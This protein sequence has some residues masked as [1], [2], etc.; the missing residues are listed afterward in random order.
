[1][2]PDRQRNDRRGRIYKKRQEEVGGREEQTI[3]R[4]LAYGIRTGVS[5]NGPEAINPVPLWG[6]NLYLLPAGRNPN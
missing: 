4:T 1:M 5:G 2:G 3:Q 6:A